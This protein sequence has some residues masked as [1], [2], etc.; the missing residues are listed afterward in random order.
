MVLLSP[1]EGELI[2][3]LS[4]LMY[5]LVNDNAIAEDSRLIWTTLAWYG[6][7]NPAYIALFSHAEAES[8]A[9]GLPLGAKACGA[10]GHA[11][12]LRYEADTHWSNYYQK[13][14]R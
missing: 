4:M 3:G 2:D 9:W 8:H 14:P 13:H 7:I 11:Q 6:V 12:E 1:V 10:T 5:W